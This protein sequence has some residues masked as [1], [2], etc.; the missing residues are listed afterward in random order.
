MRPPPSDDTG[1][2]HRVQVSH[3]RPTDCVFCDK[4]E[5][6]LKV[7]FPEG[8]PLAGFWSLGDNAADLQISPLITSCDI[9]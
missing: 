2:R 7:V 6:I 1:V 3:G 5:D 9:Q 8:I 4:C